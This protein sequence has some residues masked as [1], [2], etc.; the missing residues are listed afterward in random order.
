[1]K[2]ALNI[3]YFV[4][5]TLSVILISIESEKKWKKI[6]C[7]KLHIDI[8]IRD[9]LYFVNSEMVNELLLQKQDSLI[10]KSFED[11]NIYLLEEFIEAHPNIKKAELYLERKGELFVEVQQ[12]EP[13]FR[14]FEADTSYYLDNQFEMFPLSDNY[15]ARVVQVYCSR[16]S[17]SRIETLKKLDTM[18]QKEEFIKSLVTGIAFDTNN[19][20]TLYPRWGKHVI[21]LGEISGLEKKIEKLKAFYKSG[22]NRVGWDRYSKINLKYDGQIVCTKI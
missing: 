10:G 13:S 11:I 9:N 18:I 4:I 15:S 5:I 7:N 12:F 14:V 6:I 8:D 22:I 19:D 2:K 1:M 17:D 20:I 21:L 16:I 3:L